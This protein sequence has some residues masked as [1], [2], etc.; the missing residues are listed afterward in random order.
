M[1]NFK[2]IKLNYDNQNMQNLAY[3]Q[4]NFTLKFTT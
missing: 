1:V 2:K 3:I 4:L